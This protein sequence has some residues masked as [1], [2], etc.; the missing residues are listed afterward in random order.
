[1][2]RIGLLAILCMLLVSSFGLQSSASEL[3]GV[4]NVYT[5]M[6]LDLAEPLIDFF[7]EN[8]PNVQVDLFY[9]GST[10]LEQRIWAE[11]EAGA[12][13]ADVVWA[14][15]PALAISLK[16]MDLLHPYVSPEAAHIPDWLKDADEYYVAGRVF[17][18]GFGYNTMFLSEEEVPDTWWEFIEYGD[19]AAMASPLHSGTS[20][21]TL[22]AMAKDPNLG[23][24]WFEQARDA[25]VQVLRGTGDV[26]RALISGEFLVIK[27]IDY[28]MGV[29]AAE[30]API[31]FKAPKDG[32]VAAVSPLFIPNTAPNLENAKAFIDLILSVEGQTF[33]S[34]TGFLIPVRTD[35]PPP[36]GFPT[37]AEIM[38]LEIPYE[39]MAE[40]GPEIRQQFSEIYD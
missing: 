30:G 36:E 26:T 25:G 40:Q 22:A 1:M 38:S 9:S 28:V 27:G 31:S 39:Y 19:R 21:T 15:N 8:Y 11:N 18:M 7:E 4:V 10:E 23:W 35:V 20:F 5:S 32:T 2:K 14:A 3:S 34:E 6:Q 33:L 24:E 37:A 16:E 12:I 17:N 29:H 13:R